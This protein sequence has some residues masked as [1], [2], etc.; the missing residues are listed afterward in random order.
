MPMVRKHGAASAVLALI[1]GASLAPAIVGCAETPTSRS[2]G[3][4]IDDAAIKTKVESNLLADAGPKALQVGVDVYRG[5]VDLKGVVD[6]P[7]LVARA[8][9]DARSVEG[10]RSVRNDLVVQ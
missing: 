2:T 7:E 6:S 9:E 4:V 3:E 5:D 10:V 1:L 8:V